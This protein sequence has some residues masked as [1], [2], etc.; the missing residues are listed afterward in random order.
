MKN[1]L[2]AAEIKEDDLPIIRKL[3][4]K[5]ESE[6]NRR[7]TTDKITLLGCI[8]NP[9][10]KDLNFAPELRDQAYKYLKEVIYEHFNL[11]NVVI[12]KEKDVTEVEEVQKE[13]NI[14]SQEEPA[15]KKLKSVDTDDWLE[16]I[17]CTGETK[18]NPAKAIDIEIERYLASK[19]LEKDHT[20]TILEWWKTYEHFYPRIH[21]IAKKYLSLPGSSVSSE[22]VFSLCGQL[23]NKK[24]CRLSP[25]NID[26]LVSLNKNIDYW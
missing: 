15:P 20:L 4:D 26:L 5:L 18:S 6:I 10:T 12:K 2:Q 3:K 14:D 21:N 7:S 8:M 22:R 19:V 1:H 24:R 11:M 16:D 13:D 25:K 23:V 17:V 9:F